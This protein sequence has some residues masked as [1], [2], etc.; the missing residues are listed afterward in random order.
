MTDFTK[1]RMTNFTPVNLPYNAAGV[2]T[3]PTG[4]GTVTS[5]RPGHADRVS[6][7]T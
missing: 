2:L 1:G 6:A 5:V 4:F 7:G 3:N